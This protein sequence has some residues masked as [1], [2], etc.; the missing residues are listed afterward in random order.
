MIIFEGDRNSK[1]DTALANVQYNG[2]FTRGISSVVLDEEAQNSPAVSTRPPKMPKHTIGHAVESLVRRIG[3]SIVCRSGP[4]R[5]ADTPQ[6]QALLEDLVDLQA[7]ISKGDRNTKKDRVV[8]FASYNKLRAKR[9]QRVDWQE[10]SRFHSK[11][12]WQVAFGNKGHFVVHNTR[13]TTKGALTIFCCTY[14]RKAGWYQCPNQLCIKFVAGGHVVQC[15][16]GG[17]HHHQKS[18]LS[19]VAPLKDARVQSAIKEGVLDVLMPKV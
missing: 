9:Q 14:A 4:R 19:Q 11:E 16:K 5:V 15:W 8:C 17:N 1:E 2:H 7:T 18:L 3:L 12:Q 6:V 10:M 13:H